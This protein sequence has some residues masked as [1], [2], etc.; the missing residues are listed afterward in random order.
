MYLPEFQDILFAIK[1]I[2]TQSRQFTITNYISCCNRETEEVIG[3]NSASKRFVLFYH[4]ESTVPLS[5]NL[6]MARVSLATRS[7]HL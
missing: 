6:T 5:L 7:I 2:K 3:D 4:D 1:S